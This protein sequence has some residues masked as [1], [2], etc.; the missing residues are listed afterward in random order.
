[1]TLH[2]RPTRPHPLLRRLAPALLA[3]VV[4]AGCRGDAETQP[5][6]SQLARDLELATSAP[7]DG[8]L[9][10]QDTALAP[11]GEPETASPP[12]PAARTPRA[13]DRARARAASSAP[14]RT[15]SPVASRPAPRTPAP[16][17][18]PE[19]EPVREVAEEPAPGPARSAPSIG[20]GTRIALTSDSRVCTSSRPG[21]KLTATV[22]ETVYGSDGAQ[23]PR[24]SVVV[25]EVA[26]VTPG[27]P[28]ENSRITFRV[29]AVSVDGT[30]RPATGSGASTSALE[31]VQ[32]GRSTSS[33][34]T[35]VIGG[36]IAGAVL[37]R[38]LGGDTKSTVA[39][40]A[41]G[42]ATGAVVASRS[43]GFEGCMAAGSP[44][45]VTLGIPLEMGG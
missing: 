17:P 14:R 24:G 44:V 42:A 31:R 22:A 38:V 4:A 40:A 20:A 8:Q 41:A 10:F 32:T 9:V 5:A 23:I 43:G 26:S 13:D 29:R 21:D 3:L 2:A 11:D 37:G 30:S 16:A 39:G 34:R 1:M 6:D 33:D 28:P 36:A 25:L 45:V 27:D 7:L 35:K 12:A 18:R 15:P 19:P